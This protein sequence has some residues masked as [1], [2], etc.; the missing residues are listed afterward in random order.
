MQE[1]LIETALSSEE[2]FAQLGGSIG[3]TKACQ[4]HYRHPKRGPVTLEIYA[5]ALFPV[6]DMP[7]CLARDVR[8]HTVRIHIENNC[9]VITLT[10]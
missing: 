7:Q 3:S 1:Y 9:P 4:I 6:D 2:L 8:G 5:H 10:E